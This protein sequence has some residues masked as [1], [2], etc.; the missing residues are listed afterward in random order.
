M[1][2]ATFMLVPLL[3]DDD[4]QEWLMIEQKFKLLMN[5]TRKR[6]PNSKF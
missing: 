6:V 5:G 4:D 1:K 2:V 3:D